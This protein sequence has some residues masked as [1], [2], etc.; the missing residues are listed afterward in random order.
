M[1]GGYASGD[2]FREIRSIQDAEFAESERVDRMK[3]EARLEDIKRVV[4]D[5]RAAV[6]R[7]VERQVS[8]NLKR[9]KILT[10]GSFIGESICV[11]FKSPGSSPVQHRFSASHTLNDLYDFADV[12][13][14]EASGSASDIH[15]VSHYPPVVYSRSNEKISDSGIVNNST[16]FIKPA[17]A[18]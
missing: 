15:L 14:A 16:L 6:I 18:S 1:S 10:P 17:E 7:G 12:Q 5:E 2:T 9:R 8:L 13:Y 11:R 4:D 3:D